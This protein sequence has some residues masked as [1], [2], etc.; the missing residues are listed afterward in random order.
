M[1]SNWSIWSDNYIGVTALKG[2]PKTPFFFKM[3]KYITY[4]ALI[5]LVLLAL[6][7]PMVFALDCRINSI[8]WLWMTFASGFFAF[9]FLYQKV[10][11]WLKL[12]VIWCFVSCFMSSAP[13]ISFTMF[14]S[15][16]ICA[17][18]YM[19]CLKIED[20][21]PVKRCIQAIF[22]FVV[23]LIIMQLFGKDT[24]LNFKEK[25]P[26]ILHGVVTPIFGLIGNKMMS[27]SFMCILAPFLIYTPLNWA[28]LIIVLF[29]STSSGAV[30]AI[31]SGL[32]VYVWLRFKKLRLVILIAAIIIPMMFAYKTDKIKM[33]FLK[34]IGGGRYQVWVDTVKLSLKRPVGYG[35]STTKIIYPV[36]C[37]K[38]FRSRKDYQPVWNT[39]HCDPL[40]I[41][42]ELGFLGFILLLGWII[43]IVRNVLKHKNYIQLSGLVIIGMNMCFHFPMRMSQS[44]FIIIMFLAFCTQGEKYGR[45]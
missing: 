1:D 13:F 3:K 40:Q 31:W 6:T 35:L 5:P 9:L 42:F 7:P 28:V 29:I 17:Y 34:G 16:I 12:L 8:F 4:L 26:D 20:W 10:S 38:N 41:L 23:L 15:L 27:S 18:Y 22:F 30:L 33:F 44:V 32:G 14:W 21:T 39:T 43:S 25:T 24:L 11:V 2:V 36:I 37:D 45:S 19:L